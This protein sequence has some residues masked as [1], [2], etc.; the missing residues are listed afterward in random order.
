[1]IKFLFYS[2]IFSL[3]KF[4]IFVIICNIFSYFIHIVT[5]V[6]TISCL[7]IPT[8]ESF[9]PSL[10]W[11]SFLLEWVTYS[12]II[13]FKI[14][15]IEFLTF[16]MSCNIILDSVI[17]FQRLIIVL[18]RRLTWLDSYWTCNACKDWKEVGIFRS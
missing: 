10:F 14:F 11:L 12:L 16:W 5:I 15:W 2:F 9:Q 8:S 7:I 1:M 17:I 6:A 18:S 4:S 13:L 3:L